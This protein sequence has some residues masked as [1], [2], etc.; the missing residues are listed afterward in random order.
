MKRS[1]TLLHSECKG[2]KRKEHALPATVTKCKQSTS[3]IELKLVALVTIKIAHIQQF[4]SHLCLAESNV[5]RV[6]SVLRCFLVKHFHEN[7]WRG[8]IVFG[9]IF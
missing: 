8:K 4:L 6:G 9:Q 2:V 5:S 3:T 1:L 7:I